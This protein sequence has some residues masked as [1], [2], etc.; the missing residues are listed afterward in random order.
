TSLETLLSWLRPFQHRLH[1]NSTGCLCVIPH[2]HSNTELDY[3]CLYDTITDT[4]TH[5]HTHTLIT[6]PNANPFNPLP[7]NPSPI[8]DRSIRLFQAQY[9]VVAEGDSMAEGYVLQGSVT[10]LALESA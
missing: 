9:E 5:T 3:P 8:L 7:K 10:G 1:S 2:V 6:Q 4:H